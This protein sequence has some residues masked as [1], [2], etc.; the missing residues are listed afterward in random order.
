MHDSGGLG[1]LR[2]RCVRG[3]RIW[4]FRCGVLLL[5]L[6][7]GPPAAFLTRMEENRRYLSCEPGGRLHEEAARVTGAAVA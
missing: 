6:R 1:A 2:T 3:E 7:K 4:A 5:H